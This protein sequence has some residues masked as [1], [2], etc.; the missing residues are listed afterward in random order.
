MHWGITYAPVLAVKGET[1]L[2]GGGGRGAQYKKGGGARG[3]TIA[4]ALSA[5]QQVRGEKNVCVKMLIII[6]S[7]TY[8]LCYAFPR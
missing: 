6:I 1:M 2:G 8:F 3:V 4:N 5:P 7:T